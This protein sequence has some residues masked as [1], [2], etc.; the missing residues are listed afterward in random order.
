LKL[1]LTLE[2]PGS[3]FHGWQRQ[4]GL[5][6]VQGELERALSVLI[7]SWGK[8]AGCEAPTEVAIVGSG[9]TD[10]GVHARR[11]VASFSW[12]SNL[13]Y[14]REKFLSAIN[15]ISIAPLTVLESEVV[16]DEFD[17]RLTPH[18]K[19]YSYTLLL[20]R[21]R[22]GLFRDRAWSIAEQLDLAAMLRCAKLFKGQHDFRAFRARDCTAATTVRTILASELTRASADLLIYTVQGTGFLKQMVRTI[23]G[24][25]VA[26]GRSQMSVDDVQKL[27]SGGERKDAGP[28]A[29]ACG[30]VLEWVRYE[31]WRLLSKPTQ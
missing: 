9:R 4:N 23:V 13:E 29:P 14:N 21:G 25:L 27:M 12:P 6:T 2:Y 26:V 8:R 1:K 22:D 18:S 3:E 15:G 30:L 24:T 28:T 20:R 16:A 5:L 11:Q 17:A 7:G 19:L 10:A 31:D